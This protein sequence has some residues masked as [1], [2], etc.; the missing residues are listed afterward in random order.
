MELQQEV[1]VAVI[2]HFSLLED[3]PC[4]GAELTPL[5]FYTATFP[6]Q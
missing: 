2:M 6:D 4:L 5:D 3:L 1:P